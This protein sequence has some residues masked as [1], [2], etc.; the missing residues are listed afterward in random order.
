MRKKK[1]T[2][3]EIAKLSGTSAATVSRVLN[4]PE[5][6]NENT[7][8][9]IQ[10]AMK[11]LDYTIEAF[12][13]K[14][15]PDSLILINVSEPTNMFY[16]DIMKGINASILFHN[17]HAVFLHE[18]LSSTASI[19]FLLRQITRCGIC[20]VILCAP[21]KEIY[22]QMLSQS[23]PVVQ[24]SEY[25]S[26]EFSYVGIDNYKST[27]AA[28]D[29]IYSLGRRRTLFINGPLEYRYAR[30]RQEAFIAFMNKVGIPSTQYQIINIAKIDYNMAFASINQTLSSDRLPDSIFA[31][32]DVFAVAAAKAAGRHGIRV[33]QDMV[34]VGF[35]N[36]NILSTITTPAITSISQ[37]RFQIGYTAGELLFE[38]IQAKEASAAP[39]HVILDTE[40]II[41]DSSSV[42][43]IQDL[44]TE[45]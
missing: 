45:M 35:D 14:K 9:Q 21:I 39:K 38:A 34:I 42:N 25:S 32:S 36:I 2:I 3:A 10:N 44:K 26:T 20:G 11:R 17:Y 23:I 16:N 19:D 41:R 29:H 7:I 43:V 4:H 6:V 12:T 22:C 8:S 28:M 33:P 40:L 30:E 5:L 15:E 1:A 24:C 18:A 37:P 13:T 27:T 31:V